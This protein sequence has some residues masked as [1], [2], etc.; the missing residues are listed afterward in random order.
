MPHA[1]TPA[2]I[3]RHLSDPK[4]RLIAD[5]HKGLKL[6]IVRRGVASWVYAYTSQLDGRLRRIVI[7]AL[8]GEDL[9]L[10]SA[11]TEAD[12]LTRLIENS[13]RE[14]AEAARLGLP[15]P[16]AFCPATQAK[17]TGGRTRKAALTVEEGLAAYF[18]AKI[19]DPKPGDPVDVA[20]AKARN[21]NSRRYLASLF[22]S[23]GAG[24]SLLTR[25]LAA[26]AAMS[27]SEVRE[28]RRTLAETKGAATVNRATSYFSSFLNWCVE[29]ELGI[30]RNPLA[31][32]RREASERETPREVTATHAELKAMWHATDGLPADFARMWKIAALT[33]MRRGEIASLTSE[34]IEDEMIH[35]RRAKTTTGRRV[36]PMSSTVRDLVAEAVDDPGRMGPYLF[37]EATAGHRPFDTWSAR[38]AERRAAAGVD[39]IITLHDLRRGAVTM[40]AALGIDKGVVKLLVGHARGDRNDL[41]YD[42]HRYLDELRAAAESLQTEVLRIVA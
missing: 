32:L 25:P 11:R 24:P 28:R 42:R 35:I 6:R 22:A 38:T 16:L 29:E 5:M 41:T 10:R 20:R 39:R 27:R 14:R 2:G 34:D 23:E 40:M 12:R 30:D 1:L 26:V 36:V 4:P 15:E 7:G 33:G 37:G 21:G 3:R 8:A 31:G 9:G 17:A 13:S 18:R 19:D